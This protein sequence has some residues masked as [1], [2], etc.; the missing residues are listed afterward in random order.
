MGLGELAEWAVEEA[1]AET[2]PTGLTEAME[3]LAELAGL[4]ASEV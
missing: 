1:R 4:E 2:V 3:A